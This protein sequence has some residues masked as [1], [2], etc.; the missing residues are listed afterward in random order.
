MIKKYI[1]LSLLF[2]SIAVGGCSSG[3]DTELDDEILLH[4]A[5]SP[6]A[7]PGIGGSVYDTI[8]V[9]NT[10]FSTLRKVIDLAGLANELDDEN[11]TFTVFAPNDAAFEILNTGEAPTAL[12]VLLADTDALIRLLQYHIVSSSVDEIFLDAAAAV[13]VTLPTMIEGESLTVTTTAASIAG[14]AINGVNIS[15]TDM[16]LEVAENE[17]TSGIVHTIVEVLQ[18]PEV[19]ESSTESPGPGAVTEGAGAVQAALESAGNYT[20]FLN[21]GY[22]DAYETNAWTVFAPTDEAIAVA[23]TTLNVLDLISV[24]AG[25][26]SAADILA[27]GTIATNRGAS[28]AV[29]GTEDA[30][31]VDGKAAALVATGAAGTLVYSLD[32]ILE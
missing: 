22:L 14:L 9:Q 12:D 23:S 20:A 29:T 30:L 18:V 32:G 13:G 10:Q 25:A 8:V 11:K 16:V 21:L 3:D 31:L 4:D 2:A 1:A 6:T 28:Y 27:A 24:N 17:T 15:T 7:T 19:I 5:E 26:L